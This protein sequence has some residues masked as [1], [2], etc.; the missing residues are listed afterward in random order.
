MRRETSQA[1]AYTSLYSHI[2]LDEASVVPIYLQLANC[3]TEAIK[4]RIIRNLDWLP[5]I[6]D[7]SY[8]INVARDTVQKAY[9]YL[10][11][12]G[13]IGAYPG[14]GYY[15]V[16]THSEYQIKLFLLLN[17]LSGHKKMIYDGLMQTLD[18]PTHID[19]CIYNN[20]FN[21]FKKL[22][23]EAEANGYTHY[24]I[25]PHLSA[26]ENDILEVINGIPKDKLI[27]ID[28]QVSGITGN[29]STIYE[30]FEKD[31]YYALIKA[32][33]DLSRYKRLKLLFPENNYYPKE[34]LVGFKQFCKHFGFEAKEVSNASFEPIEEGDVFLTLAEDDLVTVIER[35]LQ[36]Q[37]R[38]GSDVG[39]L[40]Y[41]ETP[42]KRVLLNGISTISTD[43][44]FMGKKMAELIM[45]NSA[46]HVEVPF[47]YIRRGS[48]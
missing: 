20:D 34:I 19:V 17:K 46:A 36:L 23:R 29:Y 10:K 15:A 12:C 28:K 21:L 38:V 42:I 37:L 32:K 18:C 14:K 1:V 35:I 33:G 45:T 24:L 30:N 22:I 4:C 39:L 27:L 48:L 26:E 2:N 11:K 41:N 40:S 7:L 9:N 13:I 44:S 3:I 5:S 47:T 8:A 25:T 16:D 43:F 6:N 31:I